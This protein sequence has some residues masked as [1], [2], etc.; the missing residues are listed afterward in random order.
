MLVI[1]RCK[2][3]VSKW[4]FYPISSNLQA[5]LIPIIDS[6]VTTLQSND[7]CLRRFLI[8]IILDNSA[9]IRSFYSKKLT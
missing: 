7:H 3:L 4:T 8:Y 9:G 5:H 6:I 1:I 2:A